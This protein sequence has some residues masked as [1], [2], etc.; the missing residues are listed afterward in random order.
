[1]RP[2]PQPPA[3]LFP[4]D[5]AETVA[6]EPRRNSRLKL[7]G[8]PPRPKWWVTALKVLGWLALTASTAA[9]CAVL[10]IYYRYSEGLPEIP[11][12]DQYWPPIVSEV[13][14]NDGVLTGEFFNERRKVLPY[15]Q[16]P[17]RLVQAFIASEDDGFFDHMGVDFLGTSRAAF[18]TL[19]RKAQGSGSVQGG[20]TLTQQTAKA[21]LVS[22]EMELL[23]PAGIHDEA[24][25][26]V[27]PLQEPLRAE[28]DAELAAALKARGPAVN[29]DEEE[30]RKTEL[31][32]MRADAR[33]RIINRAQVRREEAIR[34]Q[35]IRIRDERTRAAFKKATSK[36]LERK[37][38]EAILAHRLEKALTKV[39]ILYLYLNN[40]YLGHHSYGVQSAAE[41]YFR[42][43]VRDLTLAQMALIG[44]LPQAPTRYSPFVHPQEAKK[45]R[46]Y[47][48]KRMLEEG[49]IS[50]AEHDQ[51][52]AEEIQ[53]LPLEDVF[54][55]VAPYFSENVRR[56]VV[57]RYGGRLLLNEG[58][59]IFA[60]MDSEKQRAA[61][62]S[63]LEG[64]LAVDKRQGFRGPVMHLG[65]E[66]ERRAFI[67]RSK[68]VMGSEPL[69]EGKYYV[70][71][72]TAVEK[73]GKW[74]DVRVGEKTGVIPIMGAR[75]ARR[76]NPEG[77]YPAMMRSSLAKVLSAGDVVV[78][79]AV[80]QKELWDDKEQYDKKLEGEIPQGVQLFRL[81]QDPEL[82][83]ALVSIEP[84]RQYLV[85][86]VGGYDFDANEYNRAFQAC[87]QPGSG[88]K[89]IEYSAAVEQLNWTEATV[90]VDSPFVGDDPAN[91]KR[92]K[93]ENYDATFHGD[94][95]VRTALV[96]SMNIPAVKT[97]A[98]V[99]IQ[100]VAEWAK[101]LGLS[102]P[103]NM[104]YSAAL[105]SSCVYP[106]ELA[107]V[108]ATI[109]R[110]G[111][112]KPTFFIRKIED[113]FG[114]TL[115]DH[116]SYDDAWAPFVDRVGG[117]YAHLFENGDRVMSGET[118]F[119][120]QDLLRGVVRE[121]TGA[122]AQRLGKP[123]AGKT[124]TTNDSF[125][126]WFNGFTK[127][128]VT[129]VWVGYDLN[130][131]PLA[132]YENGGRAALPIWLSY[133]KRAL[134]GKP[135]GEFWPPEYLEL[136]RLKIDAKTGKLAGK[137]TKQVAEMWFKKG[138]EPKDAAPEKGQ[139]D[140]GKF[141]I[142]VPN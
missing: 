2:S 72:V 65:T 55:Q 78:M 71:L 118:A 114:R 42:K 125:D 94:V 48:L 6:L 29:E 138:T 99:G 91:Q 69:Q 14:T 110:L 117:G 102:T 86:M 57:D 134:E 60:T 140:P 93:P 74:A 44:G 85:A 97:F 68:Q 127:D 132:K 30:R 50:R 130:Q 33:A 59:K 95:T 41:N 25:K 75:W 31:P 32:Q 89:P 45:R 21:V 131:H 36:K 11:R 35:F 108:Y 116:T 80:Q 12:V 103:M 111:V 98:A 112:R 81:E 23:D 133:M 129:S 34:A 53:A 1:M 67:D 96:N 66:E 40:V 51:A 13:Y 28:V 15:D 115:E 82:Q 7:G 49:M 3:S 142:N 126:A 63:M 109:D 104:D 22:A 120:M 122:P 136:V 58:M 54:H 38:R 135:Q 113:R 62:D 92:W 4:D 8:V 18:K 26:L 64:L 79:R 70:G 87:R 9:A 141:F 119:I 5:E 37:I 16:I 24:E 124:G 73:D 139:V 10:A 84:K 76:V 100:N 83:G 47:V 39:D 20:S 107:Q 105:G 121:G 137:S 106:F 88:Y 46:A 61:Q 101:K 123:A 52:S 77:W 43:D 19:L 90:L 27:G 17:K 128:L 56:D